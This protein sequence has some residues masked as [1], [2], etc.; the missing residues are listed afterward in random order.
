MGEGPGA[1]VQWTM[2]SGFGC[3]QAVIRQLSQALAD[4]GVM[5]DRLAEIATAV[6][7][8]CL[9]AIEHGN[10]CDWNEPVRVEMKTGAGRCTVAVCDRGAGMDAYALDAVVRAKSAKARDKLAWTEPRGWGWQL[11]SRYADKVRTYSRDD[12]FCVEMDFGFDEKREGPC[13]GQ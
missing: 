12:G 11:M 9:N 6:S 13:D 4:A 5:A 3:E 7:E 8:A 2:S 10:R 1:V